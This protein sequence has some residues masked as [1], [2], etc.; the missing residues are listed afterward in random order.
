MGSKGFDLHLFELSNIVLI[1]LDTPEILAQNTIILL[2]VCLSTDA[3]Q[4]SYVLDLQ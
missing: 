4:F 3:L 2:S 1:T